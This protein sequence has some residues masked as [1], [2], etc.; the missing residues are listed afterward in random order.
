MNLWQ[1]T[2]ELKEKFEKFQLKKNY[3]RTDIIDIVFS[4]QQT[5]AIYL[6]MDGP[7]I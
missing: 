3:R 5:R 4:E 1:Q 2:N 6:S 7:Q